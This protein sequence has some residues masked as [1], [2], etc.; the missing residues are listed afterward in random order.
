MPILEEVKIDYNVTGVGELSK[1]RLELEATAK[2]G[3]NIT[4][5]IKGTS[6]Q[7]DKSAKQ[8]GTS[9]T[10]LKNVVSSIGPAILATFSVGALIN[11]QKQIIEITAKFQK[12]E[13]VLTNTL[14]S[15]SA[16]QKA[17]RDIQEFAAKTPFSVD[18][19]T[20]SFVK[21]ANQGFTP[22]TKQLRQ[23][24][25]LA[26]ST[27]KS[28][29]QLSE[30]IL[31]AQTGQFERLKEFG[32]KAEKEGDKVRF[33]F[34]GVKTQVDFTSDSI[35]K[36]ILGLGDLKGV[37]GS[38][39]AISGT[40]EG[41]ISN[42]GDTFDSL[43]LAIG[44]KEAGGL[45]SAIGGLN[46]ILGELSKAANDQKSIFDNIFQAF[47]GYASSLGDYL[48]LWN[49]LA[50]ALHITGDEGITI[51]TV[52]KGIGTAIQVAQ[53]PLK[54]FI[55]TMVTLV[56]LVTLDFKEVGEDFK[57]FGEIITLNDGK[58]TG[59]I[60]KSIQ[61]LKDKQAAERA[62]LEE[63]SKLKDQE[64]N[65]SK[66]LTDKE[67]KELEKRQRDR[68]E[69]WTREVQASLRNDEER[70]KRQNESFEKTKKALNN[71]ATERHTINRVVVQDS[72]ESETEIADYK[73]AM[74]YK[75][76][77]DYI[78]TANQQLIVA[79][80]TSNIIG[81]LIQLTG[82]RT[83]A[84]AEFQK[85][86][87]VVQIG[88]STAKAIAE[89]VASAQDVGFPANLVAVATTVA[90][91]LANIAQAK[92]LIEGNSKV[93]KFTIPKAQGYATG[94]IDLKGPGTSTSDSI[95]AMLSVGESVM[96]AYETKKYRPAIDAIR[97]GID[98]E[99]L[100]KAAKGGREIDYNKLANAIVNGNKSL[101]LNAFSFDENGF[102]RHIIEGNSRTKIKNRRYSGGV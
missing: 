37:A 39:A 10:G 23:L 38:M 17:L 94:V 63:S 101:P 70:R 64:A 43:L 57:K 81:S 91:V 93:Q 33:S 6:D 34:K 36:Y 48:G 46:N 52:F 26:S 47:R 77:N 40:L 31:D 5:S 99:I 61:A 97:D 16:A 86:V 41:Q 28:F 45:S 12:Y 51:G 49:S 88:I 71:E 27:G 8:V 62:A 95:P 2:A 60:N 90:T 65:K 80:A 75:S 100:N 83:G 13:A 53:V 96:T 92:S 29:D 58:V 18:E 69:A 89:G 87:A 44:R 24:G 85:G 42:L 76:L 30:A 66:E 67:K 21:L 98:P 4:T 102:S 9:A 56:D 74:F 54:L 72:E 68:D 7:F 59:S 55:N 11:F 79:Q 3:N 82:D 22:N 1:A 78:Q 84:L 19:L 35:Q 14:G 32:I 50:K 73:R 20:A 25:D 15:N